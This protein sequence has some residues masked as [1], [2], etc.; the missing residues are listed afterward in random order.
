MFFTEA[1]GKPSQIRIAD[2]AIR[3]KNFPENDE[4]KLDKSSV[5]PQLD[6]L[7]PVVIMSQDFEGTFPP[8]SGWELIEL[9]DPSSSDLFGK[10]WFGDHRFYLSTFSI[11]HLIKLWNINPFYP[12]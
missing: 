5:E 2:D 3:I 4:R 6:L 1:D 8:S 7:Y 10:S 11:G 12:T 9:R